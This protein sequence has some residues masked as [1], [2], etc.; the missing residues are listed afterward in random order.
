MQWGEDPIGR[1]SSMEVHKKELSQQSSQV[2][3]LEL[4]WVPG[5]PKYDPWTIPEQKSGI[6]ELSINILDF[7]FSEN[8][9]IF[10]IPEPESLFLTITMWKEGNC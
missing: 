6:F 3:D 5:L 9:I 1:V 4:L 2:V 7:S 8:W 10:F